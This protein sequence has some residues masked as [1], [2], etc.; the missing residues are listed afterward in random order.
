MA[1]RGIH[2]DHVH[3]GL[4]QCRDAPLGFTA[5]AHRRADAQAFVRILGGVRIVV[6][7]LDVLDGDQSA[8]LEGV[9]DHQHLLDAV[10]VQQADDFVLG[11]TFLH[12]DQLVLAG[13]D[14]LH[15]IVGLLL[16]AQVAAGDDADQPVAFFH[17]RHTG[18][19]VRARDVHDLAD[20]GMR[21]HGDRVADHAGLELLHQ[22]HFRGLAFDGHVLVDDA[23]TAALRHGDGEPRLGHGI[24]GRRHQWNVEVDRAGQPG[25]SI[26]IA[27][28]DGGM[29]GDEIDVVVGQGLGE[30]AH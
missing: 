20:R 18:D 2:H 30:D 25:R 14:V 6:R 27:R 12:R 26:D 16:E 4:G 23:D 29:G 13:H 24:H 9:V 1:V 7:L 5:H 28:Q 21:A 17:H 11:R 10:L 22:P 19:V 3:A 15:R 8:Q